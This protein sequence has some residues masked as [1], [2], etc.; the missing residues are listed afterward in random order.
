MF[1][2]LT[3]KGGVHPKDNKSFTKSK[4]I[5]KAQVPEELIFPLSQ[6]IGAPCTP[7]VNI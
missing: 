6:H 4:P 1:K 2:K 5:V 3:F 7:C